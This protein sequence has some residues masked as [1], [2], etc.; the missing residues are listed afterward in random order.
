MKIIKEILKH[1]IL[2]GSLVSLATFITLVSF[3]AQDTLTSLIIIFSGL[4][5]G[6]ITMLSLCYMLWPDELIKKLKKYN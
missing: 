5:V 6:V 1:I 4:W 3:T 2:I